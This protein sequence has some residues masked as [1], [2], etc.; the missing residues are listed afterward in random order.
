MWPGVVFTARALKRGDV[1]SKIM[2][3]VPNHLF[4]EASATNVELEHW[5]KGKW[6]RPLEGIWVLYKAHFKDGRRWSINWYTVGA[7]GRESGG[8]GG[9]IEWWDCRVVWEPI[10]G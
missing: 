2:E 4:L 7:V 5:M 10:E 1:P 6:G 3:A 9:S 8:D